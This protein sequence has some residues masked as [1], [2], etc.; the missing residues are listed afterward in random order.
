MWVQVKTFF[1]PPQGIK[2]TLPTPIDIYYIVS[3]FL[4]YNF[5][6]ISI[7]QALLYI[8]N[9]LNPVHINMILIHKV[10]IFLIRIKKKEP[11]N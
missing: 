3:Y 6:L 2:F 11:L 1:F 4:N 8:D 9:M 10:S 5:I 7:C